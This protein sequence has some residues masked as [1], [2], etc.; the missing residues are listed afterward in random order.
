MLIPYADDNPTLRPPVVTIAIIATCVL[1][2]LYQVSLPEPAAE[3]FVRAFALVPGE[4]YGVLPPSAPIPEYLTLITSMFLHGSL[5]HL[6]GNMLY[7]WVFGNNIEDAMGPVR[8]TVFYVVCGL[9]AALAQ[10]MADLTSEDPMIGAS[11]AISGVLGA[12]LILHPR[13]NIR[14]IF[15][16]IIFPIRINLPAVAV[17]G[18]WIVVQ[19][20][21]ASMTHGDMG[22]VAWF[23]HV[24]GFVA[25]AALIPFFRDGHIPLF[26]GARR[27]GPWG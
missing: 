19:A 24:G 25:G 5:L 12:Y 10:A 9:A 7:L 6:G 26:G 20:I 17:L 27:Q 2:F 16:L 14:N 4:L 22:G 3:A 13:A 18:F 15:L 11:G 8:F 1:V 23:A 21:N